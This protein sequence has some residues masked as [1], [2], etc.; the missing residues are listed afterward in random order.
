VRGYQGQ[1]EI[2]ESK[3]CDLQGGDLV[4]PA[5]AG[6][7]RGRVAGW[8]VIDPGPPLP[9]LYCQYATTKSYLQGCQGDP[10]RAPAMPTGP[11]QR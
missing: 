8:S 2:S 10:D 6:A 1:R 7:A 11:G 3:S 5:Q 9:V 4:G